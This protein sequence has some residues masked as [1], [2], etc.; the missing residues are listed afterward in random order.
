MGAPIEVTFPVP[1]QFGHRTV[2]D[3][4]DAILQL[5]ERMRLVL[6][7]HRVEGLSLEEIAVVLEEPEDLVAEIFYWAY[8]GV[9]A[10][11]SPEASARCA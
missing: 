9:G 8:V 11:P 2:A 7:L 10:C 6:S 3:L 5:D 4:S 1:V